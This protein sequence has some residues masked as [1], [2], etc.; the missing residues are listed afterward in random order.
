MK[1]TSVIFDLFGTLVELPT[2]SGRENVLTKMAS[3][4]SIP[5]APFEQQWRETYDERETGRLPD[6]RRSLDHICRCLSA[7]P[8]DH[9][10]GEAIKL[11]LEYFRELLKPRAK[12][13]EALTEIRK[14]KLKTGLI[15]DCTAEVPMVWGETPFVPLIDE[16]VFS[17]QAGMKKPDPHIYLIATERLGVKPAECLYIGDGGSRELTGA[18]KAGMKAIQI[19]IEEPDPDAYA[20]DCEDWAGPVVASLTDVLLMIKES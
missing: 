8:N 4:L 10:I 18:S 20:I 1:Y 12:A 2:F 19:R 17:C 13:I 3:V 6:F 7:H 5:Y 16:C 14:L 15:S 9:Q 11:R